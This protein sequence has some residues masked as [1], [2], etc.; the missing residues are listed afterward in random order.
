MLRGM[1]DLLSIGRFARLSGLSIGALRHYH[2]IGLLI[3]AR[4][5]AETSY[6]SY[7][8]AQLDDAQ[9]IA[10]LRELDLALPEIR[11]VLG[12]DSDG[13]QRLLD[14]TPR[15]PWRPPQPASSVRSTG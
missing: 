3:P 12:A 2:E 4:V 10:R 13:R 8:R 5:D 9:L 7:A 1:D 14:G 6:R 11:A 15:P